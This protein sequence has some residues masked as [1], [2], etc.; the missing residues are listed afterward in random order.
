[1]EDEQLS[2]FVAITSA[3]PEI[4]R[5][6]LDLAN[7]NLERAIELYFEDPGLVSHVQVGTGAPVPSSAAPRSHL[8]ASFS[9]PSGRLGREDASGVIHIDSDDE[10][11]NNTMDDDDDDGGT[12]RTNAAAA[13]AAAAAAQEQ[14]DALMAKRL[15][16]EL[17]GAGGSGADDNVRA[18]IARTTETL[19]DPNPAWGNNSGYDPAPT[20]LVDQLRRQRERTLS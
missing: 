20:M 7:D 17:Y 11:T 15:Q 2:N 3:D 8:P 14:E 1:M 16:E 4:A 13:V 6:F 5:G 10:D 19:V 12:A 9:T 18:P